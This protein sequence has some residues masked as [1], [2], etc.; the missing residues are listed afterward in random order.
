MGRQKRKTALTR[1]GGPARPL[2]TKRELN[3]WGDVPDLPDGELG[4]RN[5]WA[6]GKQIDRIPGE[7]T[8]PIWV[9]R[10]MRFHLPRRTLYQQVHSYEEVLQRLYLNK[11][12]VGSG[13]QPVLVRAVL[14]VFENILDAVDG[15]LQEPEP[16]DRFLGHHSVSLSDWMKEGKGLRFVNSWGSKWGNGGS[17]FLSEE[18]FVK[19][20][21]E[22]W[23]LAVGNHGLNVPDG[24][25]FFD[26]DLSRRELAVAWR[27]PPVHGSFEL[28]ASQ[29]LRW[30]RAKS[31]FRDG[32]KLVGEVVDRRGVRLG[33]VHL[34]VGRQEGS[35]TAVLSEI[36]V[37]PTYRRLGVGRRLYEWAREHARSQKCELLQV[38]VYEAD[39]SSSYSI[40]REDLTER[41][42]LQWF[43]PPI[44]NVDGDATGAIAAQY[45]Q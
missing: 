18:Y 37:W 6:A 44:D 32:Y 20:S 14:A 3:P 7:W 10:A 11:M 34:D 16:G 2:R 17:G 40:P 29:R 42:G 22:T 19:H 21:T 45:L 9:L 1:T 30:Y 28:P 41:L 8:Y 5:S 4:H 36:F 33:W 38:L 27:R 31:L 25:E 35:L 24:F 15:E 23:A 12:L 26:P 39:L 43:H 13:F